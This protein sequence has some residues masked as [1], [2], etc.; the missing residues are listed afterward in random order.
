[1]KLHLRP[2]DC[3]LLIPPSPFSMLS[4]LDCP[5]DFVATTT[6]KWGGGVQ[7][8]KD[9]QDS[10]ISTMSQLFKHGIVVIWTSSYISNFGDQA[11][12]RSV[13]YLLAP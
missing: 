6:L 3:V 11:M 2:T 8:N 12:Q 5:I 13:V 9:V 10:L 1:M 4:M 7:E